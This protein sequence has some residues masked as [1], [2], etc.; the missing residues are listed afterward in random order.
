MNKCK[1]EMDIQESMKD[2]W[3]VTGRRDGCDGEAN[4]IESKREREGRLEG[5][6]G[7]V[8]AGKKGNGMMVFTK[9]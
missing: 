8:V 1:K 5:I 7:G 6:E 2:W 9:R 4:G 3:T